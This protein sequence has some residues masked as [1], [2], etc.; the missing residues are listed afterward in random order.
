MRQ[1]YW[2][3]WTVLSGTYQEILTWIRNQLGDNDYVPTFVDASVGDDTELEVFFYQS[4]GLVRAVFISGFDGANNNVVRDIY[5][6]DDRLHQDLFF[7]LNENLQIAKPFVI[8]FLVK[9]AGVYAWVEQVF[10]VVDTVVKYEIN[11]VIDERGGLQF[12]L[13]CVPFGDFGIGLRMT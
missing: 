13:A 11:N 7:S 8:P 2:Y 3:G 4:W 5:T 1:D 12:K 9:K 6:L 10:F